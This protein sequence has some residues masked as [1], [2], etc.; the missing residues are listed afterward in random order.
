[1]GM[2]RSKYKLQLGLM[3]ASPVMRVQYYKHSIAM[4]EKMITRTVKQL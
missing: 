2:I 1:M 4:V 3:L